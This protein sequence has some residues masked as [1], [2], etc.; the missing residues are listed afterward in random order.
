LSEAVAATLPGSDAG[1]AVA[2]VVDATAGTLIACV[3]AGATAVP[4][5]AAAGAASAVLA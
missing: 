2:V 3:A 4:A 1:F 5:A